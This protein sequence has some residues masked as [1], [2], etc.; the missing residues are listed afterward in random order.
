[1]RADETFSVTVNDGG[2]MLNLY[3]LTNVP[4]FQDIGGPNRV[5]SSA[6]YGYDCRLFLT[7]TRQLLSAGS[8]DYGMH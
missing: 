1:M 8:D 6:N 4:I 3:V 2:P 7:L 5:I